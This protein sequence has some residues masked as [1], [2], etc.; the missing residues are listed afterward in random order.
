MMNKTH[1]LSSDGDQINSIR[2]NYSLPCYF[3]VYAIGTF[4]DQCANRQ[5]SLNDENFYLVWFW[6]NV[7]LIFLSSRLGAVLWTV[8][9]SVTKWTSNIHSMHFN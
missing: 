8:T 5:V 9:V 6:W 3:Y 1:K 2:K 7:F 4:K